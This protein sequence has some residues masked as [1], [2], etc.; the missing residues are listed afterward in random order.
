MSQPSTRRPSRALKEYVR[1][2]AGV[3]SGGRRLVY[4]NLF[5][6][7]FLQFAGPDVRWTSQ[8][9]VVC[10]GGDSFWGLSFDVDAKTFS[11]P[12]FN[13]SA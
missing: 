2:Y 13:G 1:Q 9:V 12:S 10:D 11:P 7:S 8:P 4:V 5:H 3:V 6:E